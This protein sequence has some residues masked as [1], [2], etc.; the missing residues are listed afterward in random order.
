[1]NRRQFLRYSS[2]WGI[3]W[4]L[5]GL[6]SSCAQAPPKPDADRAVLQG[7]RII[8]PHAHPDQFHHVRPSRVDETST[9]RAIKAAGMAASAFAAV[10]DKE[11]FNRSSA[12]PYYPS[13]KAQ[14]QRAQDLVKAGK[15]K[16][17][18][19]AADV[20]AVLNPDDPPG[21]IMAIEGGDP[22]DGK[23][24]RV[25][26]FYQMGVRIITVVHYRNNELGDVM[27]QYGA[28]NPGPYKNGLT[29]AGRKVIERMEEVGMVVDVA[30]AHPTTLKDIAGMNPKPLLDS[31]TNPCPTDDPRRCH[32]QRS[33]KDMERV[34]KTGGVVCTW[35]FAF[36]RPDQ[37]R[38]TFLDWARETLE[39]KKRL[40]MDHVGLGTDGGGGIPRLIEGYRDVRD[41]ARLVSAMQEIGLS[42]EDIKAYMGGNVHRVLQKCIG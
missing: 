41:L 2:A 12:I 39:M 35:P 36:N 17:V 25:D 5:G 24:E 28:L 29:Q 4:S 8:D 13:T 14:L 23:P 1:M 3:S 26:E 10:G 7:L 6:I 11:F 33:W 40:G 32:R 42:P 20:P 16:L 38:W 18:L 9:L 30:H 19:K 34:A 31:H 22:L 15:V 21:A 27:A 37:Q